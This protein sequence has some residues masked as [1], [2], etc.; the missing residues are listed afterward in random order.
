MDARPETVRWLER[1]YEL[2]DGGRVREAAAE[3]LDPAC[4]FRIANATPVGF[5][6]AA[7]AL[8]PLVTG[9]RHRI[10]SV[11]ESDDGTI[12]CELEITYTR[13]DGSSVTLPGALFAHV[14]DGRFI[15]QRAYTDQEPLRERAS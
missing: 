10:T 13:H 9:T 4:T 12:A 5:M 3:F 15:E 11:L 1:Y 7:R 6:D 14:R 2:L 8:A